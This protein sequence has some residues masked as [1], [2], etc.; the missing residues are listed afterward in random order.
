V[1][2]QVRRETTTGPLSLAIH[3]DEMLLVASLDQRKPEKS[4]WGHPPHVLV[5]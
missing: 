2:A 4:V 5:S 1:Y 3:S